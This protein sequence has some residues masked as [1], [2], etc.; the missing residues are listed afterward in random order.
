MKEYFTESDIN[1]R[2]VLKGFT[3]AGLFEREGDYYVVLRRE[4]K[5]NYLPADYKYATIR[6]GRAA[7][8]KMLDNAPPEIRLATDMTVFFIRGHAVLDPD[9]EKVAAPT[10]EGGVFWSPQLGCPCLDVEEVHAEEQTV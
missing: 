6:A 4:R 5:L 7:V 1:E 9:R 8:R 3:I 2:R 10:I